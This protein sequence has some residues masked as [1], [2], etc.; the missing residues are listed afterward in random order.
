[1]G[2]LLCLPP[3]SHCMF[4]FRLALHWQI[5]IGMVA[6]AVIGVSLN[7][8]ASSRSVRLVEDLPP[9]FSAVEIDDS[10]GRAEIRFYSGEE[11]QRQVIIDPTAA[12]ED[13]FASLD[14]LRKQDP[15]VASFYQTHGGS[16]A[17]TLGNLFR[18]L[19]NL[20]LRMLQMVAVP[21]IV[22][23]LLTGVMGLSGQAVGRMFSRTLTYYL[24]T[25]LL[26]ITTG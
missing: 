22:A 25:S 8:F 17:R 1:C 16:W 23:S 14:E 6:G 9:G 12:G 7:L 3:R 20:F 15:Q 26:A 18:R 21:L 19:G 10:S 2:L 5:L 11:L 13:T 4:P 24:T